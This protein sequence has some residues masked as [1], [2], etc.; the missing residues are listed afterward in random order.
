MIMMWIDTSVK[1]TAILHQIHI[2]LCR[3]YICCMLRGIFDCSSLAHST[4][5]KVILQVIPHLRSILKKKSLAVIP[6]IY[7]HL[8]PFRRRKGQ[9]FPREPAK[10]ICE[11]CT[12]NV[13]CGE[14]SNIILCLEETLTIVSLTCL[15]IFLVFIWL[16]LCAVSFV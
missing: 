7:S 3:W 14:K 2:W 6:I 4:L 13:W 1:H 11:R 9:F 10:I 5:C 8:Q 16:R 15:F 12:H